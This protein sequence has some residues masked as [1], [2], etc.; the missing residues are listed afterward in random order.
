MSLE[1]VWNRSNRRLIITES[2]PENM[3][4]SIF[5]QESSSR[6][7]ITVQLMLPYLTSPST[8]RSS[9]T[10]TRKQTE[11]LQ[12]IALEWSRARV[13][14][15][16]RENK[17]K[18]RA[19]LGAL[20][21]YGLQL[22]EYKRC[23]CCCCCCC[24][25]LALAKCLLHAR[26]FAVARDVTLHY[27]E[28]RTDLVNRNHLGIWLSSFQKNRNSLAW[29][30]VCQSCDRVGKRRSE[31]EEDGAPRPDRSWF[32]NHSTAWR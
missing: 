25:L 28:L 16:L 32:K 1:A 2:Y 24:C 29:V 4:Q 3:E 14:Q 18:L 27:R 5:L 11:T 26:A 12:K 15:K 17:I 30:Q 23:C 19:V 22:S 9:S 8:P 21:K 20:Q 13:V 6:R 10:K 7:D 31:Q